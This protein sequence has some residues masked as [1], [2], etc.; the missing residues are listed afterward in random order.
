VPVSDFGRRVHAHL[1][2]ARLTDREEAVEVAQAHLGS[3]HS[4]IAASFGQAGFYSGDA[5]P[6]PIPTT[7]FDA[8][9]RTRGP[10]VEAMRSLWIG[11][12]NP[13]D[14]RFRNGDKSGSDIEDRRA[15]PWEHP[16]AALREGWWIS[17]ERWTDKMLH[18]RVGDLVVVQRQRPA[19]AERNAHESVDAD[20]MY[21]GLASVLATT[22]W[23]DEETDLYETRACLIPLCHFNHPVPITTAKKTMHRLGDSAISKLPAAADR[24]GMNRQLSAVPL[25]AAV[26][27]LSVCGVSPEILAE[28]DLATIAGLLAATETGNEEYLALRYDHQVRQA[29]RHANEMR[30]EAEAQ[31]WAEAKGYTFVSRDATKPLL[32]YD[33]LFKDDAEEELQIEVKGYSTDKLAEV[34]LQPSQVHRATEAAAGTPPDWRLYALL[35]AS[36]NRPLE[37]IRLP[38]EVVDLVE[39]GGIGVNKTMTS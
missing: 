32:G 8:S 5:D 36:T 22:S 39:S 30:A 16:E 3:L 24:T 37:A 15:F 11:R 34:N 18:A 9:E 10:I 4:E 12:W 2:A 19:E 14:K 31:T 7:S 25:D 20:R 38:Q 29:A 13:S 6:Y 26:E 21:V 23:L 1:G 33:L 35:R 28:G 17:T 27:L